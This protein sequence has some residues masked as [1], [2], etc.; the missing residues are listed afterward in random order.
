MAELGELRRQEVF[1]NLKRYLGMAIQATYRLEEATNNQSRALELK[2]DKRL[3][4]AR[5]LKNSEADLLKAG[6]DLKEMTKAKDRVEL[7]LVG[8]QKQAEDQ[9]RHLLETKDQLKIAKEQ[10]TDLKKKLAE[11]EGAKNIAE[12]ARD[13]ALRA[14]EEA[15]FPRTEAESFKEKAEEEAFALGVAKT[16]ATFKAQVPGV[17]NVYYPFAIRE[18]APSSSEVEVAPEEAETAQSEAALVI[19]APDELAK[20]SELS[21]ATETN[22][23][24]NP[25]ALR[26][27]A[28]S[29]TNAQALH[30][31]KSTFSVEPLQ[32]APPN[33]GSKDPEA[34]STQLSKEGIKIKLKK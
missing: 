7:G 18:T 22:K 2:R 17:E 24:L 31:E 28:E 10:I 26:K 12:W 27:T 15:E 33:K 1:L 4:A 30:A 8:A 23:G 5:T 11:A 34:V 3:N 32:I 16:Q 19:T 25:E 29:T 14:K 9:T 13:E 6:E 20:E 21:G